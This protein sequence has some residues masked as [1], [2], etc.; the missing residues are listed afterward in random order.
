MSVR[1]SARWRVL[2][3]EIMS[4]S[5]RLVGEIVSMIPTFYSKPND[6]K[7]K[8]GMKEL[9]GVALWLK[10]DVKRMSSIISP[11]GAQRLVDKHNRSNQNS[12]W[13]KLRNLSNLQNTS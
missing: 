10:Q 8:T 4:V 3:G 5:R 7:G 6:F 1:G 11:Q 9:M 13:N 12:E 2:G